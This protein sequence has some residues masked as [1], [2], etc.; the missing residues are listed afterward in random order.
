MNILH[1]IWCLPR[2]SH[3]FLRKTIPRA[4]STV[5]FFFYDMFL[6]LA[7]FSYAYT[8]FSHIVS[9]NGVCHANAVLELPLDAAHAAK[10]Y[11]LHPREICL[12]ANMNIMTAG[13]FSSTVATILAAIHLAAI[14]CRL[15]ELSYPWTA[16][17][18]RKNDRDIALHDR[19]IDIRGRGK[20][21]IHDQGTATSNRR[22]RL[23]TISEE[24]YSMGGQ[25]VRKRTMI[26][27]KSRS[28]SS[29]ARNEISTGP[30]DVLLE[31]LT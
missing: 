20:I 7:L 6:V 1:A 9:S 3:P 17:V 10:Q 31:L 29:K 5:L 24:E 8:D 19:D 12:R 27:K 21:D 25:A 18:K 22:G 11:R 15:A 4:V 16:R 23:T 2:M 28:R 14:L 30:S 13:I 26:S